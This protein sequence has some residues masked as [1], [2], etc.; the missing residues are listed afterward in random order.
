[1]LDL[2][3][4]L[5]CSVRSINM[6]YHRAVIADTKSNSAAIFSSQIYSPENTAH[7]FETGIKSF[8]G[9]EI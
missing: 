1:M 2:L 8:G 9:L 7:N 5:N 6:K 3:D 4:G